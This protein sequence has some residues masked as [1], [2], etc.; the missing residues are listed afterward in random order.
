MAFLTRVLSPKSSVRKSFKSIFVTA[1]LL[2]LPRFNGHLGASAAMR[3]E[4]FHGYKE[5]LQEIQHRV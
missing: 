5:K 2:G 3:M 4:V 1:P